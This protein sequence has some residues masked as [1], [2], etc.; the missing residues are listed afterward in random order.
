MRDCKW[1]LYLQAQKLRHT[2]HVPVVRIQVC[3][4]I[5][6]RE[7]ERYGVFA[8]EEERMGL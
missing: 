8:Q 5:N 4:H 2:A 6:S 3:G 7:T 1:E